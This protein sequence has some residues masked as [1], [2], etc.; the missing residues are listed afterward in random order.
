[1]S[2][3]HQTKF[4]SKSYAQNSVCMRKG[5]Y[6]NK[7]KIIWQR[8]SACLTKWNYNTI[9]DING[10]RLM[11]QP[12]K[13]AE[14]YSSRRLINTWLHLKL[15]CLGPLVWFRSLFSCNCH[16]YKAQRR[17]KEWRKK[18]LFRQNLGKKPH[19]GLQTILFWRGQSR[20][21]MKPGRGVRNG[22]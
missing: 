17:A 12:S 4:S 2:S 14:R 16:V 18:H 1:M 7:Q 6:Q 19:A 11:Q 8:S 10:N 3:P 9:L 21:Q 22:G 15:R 13:P 5:I 20:A